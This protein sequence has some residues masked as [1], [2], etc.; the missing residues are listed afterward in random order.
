MHGGPDAGGGEGVRKDAHEAAVR[1]F[2]SIR[3]RQY[4]GIHAI[5]FPVLDANR[6]A[7]A[8]LTVPMLPRVD[9]TKQASLGEVEKVLRRS[10]ERLSKR[11]G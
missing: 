5:S 6:H 2:A 1:G 3:S 7:I 4:S 9:G 11:I 10:A 8:A